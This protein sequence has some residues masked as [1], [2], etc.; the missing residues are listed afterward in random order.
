MTLPDVGIIDLMLGIPDGPK[1]D[2]YAF[3]KPLRARPREP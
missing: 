1:K 3:L 2:W